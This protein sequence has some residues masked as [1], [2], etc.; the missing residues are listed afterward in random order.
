MCTLILVIRLNNFAIFKYSKEGRMIV[1][2]NL[3]FDSKKV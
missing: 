1:K 2:L 3:Y